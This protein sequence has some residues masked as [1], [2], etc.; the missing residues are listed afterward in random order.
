MGD[1]RCPPPRVPCLLDISLSQIDQEGCSDAALTRWGWGWSWGW[2]G[3]GLG[4][5]TGWLGPRRPH[6][7]CASTHRRTEAVARSA[8]LRVCCRIA[9]CT[10]VWHIRVLPGRPGSAGE[11]GQARPLYP[12]TGVL[13]RSTQRPVGR[14]ASRRRAA[15]LARRLLGCR[16]QPALCAAAWPPPAIGAAAAHVCVRAG[17]GL[18]GHGSSAR[19]PRPTSL[20]YRSHRSWRL[21]PE[22]SS[23]D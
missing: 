13:P 20:G 4:H 3:L 22:P 10:R 5:T 19:V 7:R 23:M 6:R 1:G 11:G 14:R 2:R 21:E 17:S 9:G 18:G 15:E 12:E 8:G 16:C